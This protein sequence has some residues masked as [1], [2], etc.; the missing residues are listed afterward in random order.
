MNSKELKFKIHELLS[1][2][3]DLYHDLMQLDYEVK[4][5][6]SLNIKILGDTAIALNKIYHSIEVT[7]DEDLITALGKKI[8]S[9][10]LSN[11]ELEDSVM[12]ILERL[13]S[14]EEKLSD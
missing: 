3:N 6:L 13:S 7:E 8:D 5:K 9:E 12:Q 2:L 14:I 10:H 11:L 1:N 4:D